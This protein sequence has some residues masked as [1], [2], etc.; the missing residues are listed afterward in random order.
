M[1]YGLAES[2]R[3]STGKKADAF[4]ISEFTAAGHFVVSTENRVLDAFPDLEADHGNANGHMAPPF[5]LGAGGRAGMFLAQS[6]VRW[7]LCYRIE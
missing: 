2:P 6:C 7:T 3:E 5:R 4:E 1:P